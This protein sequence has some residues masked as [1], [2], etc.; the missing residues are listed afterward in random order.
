MNTR[1]ARAMNLAG[2]RSLR[3]NIAV[4]DRLHLL[5]PSSTAFPLTDWV[6]RLIATRFAAGLPAEVPYTDPLDAGID[7]RSLI[8]LEAPGPMTNAF[9]PVPGSGF[10][11]SDN[12]D[13]TAE[14]LWRAR[15]QSGLID[16]VLIWNAVP[17]YLGPTKRKP[18]VAEE[19]EGGE[20]LR[21]LTQM[22]PELHTVV[23][24]G[25]HAK[26]TWRRFA[27]PRLR[28]AMRTV[29]SFHSGNQAMNQPGLRPH[30]HAAL[31]RAATDWRPLAAG[32]DASIMIEKD[33]IGAATNQWYEDNQG[34]RIDIHPR[35]W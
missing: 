32:E 10:I 21:E 31:A 2:P 11:S 22:L 30:L 20:I 3:A 29:E 12:D 34:D 26:D 1:Y 25:E 4:S 18:R 33:R 9:N 35:W 17:W 27:R 28:T 16:G 8:I 5:H 7:A 15:K 13:A 23:P 24:L 6:D 19:A 14:N